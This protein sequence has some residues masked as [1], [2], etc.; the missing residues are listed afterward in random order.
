[1]ASSDLLTAHTI[2]KTIDPMKHIIIF[3]TLIA[4]SL[5]GCHAS[6][7][8]DLQ[9]E[10]TFKGDTV[11]LDSHSPIVP[12]LQLLKLT[13]QPFCSEFRTVGTVRAEAGQ[14]A[15]IAPPYEGRIV[16]SHIRLGQHVVAGQTLFEL[17]SS[18]FL[19]ATKAYF[20]ART[21]SDLATRNYTRKKELS[22]GGIASAREVEEARTDAEN[23]QNELAQTTAALKIFHIHPEGLQI[24]QPMRIPSPIT[25]DVVACDL[26]VG[27]Y[28]KS[29]AA[30]VATVANLRNVWVVALVKENYF[31][32]IHPGDRVEIYTDAE[33]HKVIWGKIDH[34]GEII[35]E[36][37]RSVQVIVTCDNSQRRLKPGMFTSVHFLA[38]PHDAL[39][40]PSSAIYQEEQ[41]SYV[42]VAHPHQRYVRRN[43][44]VESIKGDSVHL[45]SGLSAGEQV[46]VKGGIYL[47][48]Q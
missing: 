33:P 4:M 25:G 8:A 10:T 24:G 11:I 42:F 20:E 17:S 32:S 14:I 30:P 29:D 40:L 3:E 9:H 46:V 45:L 38:A 12:K 37:T 43:V 44:T 2:Y 23:T 35:D 41:T 28:L 19:E 6:Q 13:P 39:L 47:T 27:Q 18:D 15:E 21:N 5:A 26:T 36:Q 1:M 16:R 34:I 48:E 7:T 22:A 31:S